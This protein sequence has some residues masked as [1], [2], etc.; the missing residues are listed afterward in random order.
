MSPP[1][2]KPK[3]ERTQPYTD[4]DFASFLNFVQVGNMITISSRPLHSFKCKLCKKKA[5]QHKCIDFVTQVEES[6]GEVA[7]RRHIGGP[8]GCAVYRHFEKY[9]RGMITLWTLGKI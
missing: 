9:H 3:F 7:V 8:K 6:T 4:I 5:I 1:K 2:P